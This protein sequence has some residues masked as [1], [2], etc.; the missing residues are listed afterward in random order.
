[1]SAAAVRE[2]WLAMWE[3][4]SER[5]IA[6]KE[7][8][9]ALRVLSV[10]YSA[11]SPEDRLVVDELLAELLASGDETMRFDALALIRQFK[12]TSAL[13]ALRRL[14][15]W[16]EGQTWPG[17]PYEWAKVNRVIGALAPQAPEPD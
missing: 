8:Q 17:A 10:R 15:G 14:A 5:A 16:L 13:P 12:I 9:D 2:A 1:M 7:S 3:E 4:V 11:L 6:N